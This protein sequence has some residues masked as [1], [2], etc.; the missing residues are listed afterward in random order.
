MYRNS[1]TNLGVAVVAVI[2]TGLFATSPALRSLVF[3]A[4][5]YLVFSILFVIHSRSV[6]VASRISDSNGRRNYLRTSQALL[7]TALVAMLM[8]MLRFGRDVATTPEST[9]HAFYLSVIQGN[10]LFPVLMVVFLFLAATLYYQ[11]RAYK[12]KI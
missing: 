10:L 7:A 8:I 5:I 12:T 9:W 3:V 2:V 11:E 4:A 6:F 1:L